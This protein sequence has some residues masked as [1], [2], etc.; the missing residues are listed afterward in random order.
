MHFKQQDFI[1]TS[2][3][4]SSRVH[5]PRLQ[6]MDVVLTS[7][8]FICR[9]R[10]LRRGRRGPGGAT[11]TVNNDPYQ[12]VNVDPLEPSPPYITQQET[13]E[14]EYAYVDE[15]FPPPPPPVIGT[16][17]GKMA[18]HH[19]P[20]GTCTSGRGRYDYHN[21]HNRGNLP[22]IPTTCG[23]PFCTPSGPCEECRE[24]RHY[25]ELDPDVSTSCSPGST[26]Y[27]H[28][29]SQPLLSQDILPY[30]GYERRHEQGTV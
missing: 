29:H 15:F 11:K 26:V 22:K 6:S 2:Q 27:T 23:H 9:Q 21:G 7:Q 17:T 5:W 4:V 16:G 25:F 24:S 18:N 1:V 12:K 20:E 28:A 10:V 13:S 14:N 19:N 3:H 8:R 30:P